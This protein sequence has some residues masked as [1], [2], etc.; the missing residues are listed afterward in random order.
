MRRFVLILTLLAFAFNAAVAQAALHSCDQHSEAAVNKQIEASQ[1]AAKASK[2]CHTSEATPT[3]DDE[4]CCG[5]ICLCTS[6]ATLKTID[7][8]TIADAR[9][10]VI[11]HTPLGLLPTAISASTWAE[12]PPPK[13]FV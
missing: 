12:N 7:T 8:H 10:M 2:P 11:K 13:L 5:K 3:Q 6:K 9:A 1:Q 4:D